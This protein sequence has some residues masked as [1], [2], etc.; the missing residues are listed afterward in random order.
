MSRR[1]LVAGSLATAGSVSALFLAA[2]GGDSDDNGAASGTT[3][4]GGTTGAG[5]GTAAAPAA[6]AGGTLRV[7]ESAAPDV[8]D[9]AVT[10]HAGSMSWGT[11]TV[12]TGLLK[13]DADVQIVDH[14]AGLPEQPDP[15]TYVFKLK[16][17]IKWHNQPPANGREFIAEDAVYGLK[18]FTEN[19]PG[20]T[21]SSYLEPVDKYEVIDKSTFRLTTKQ[22]FAPLLA[23]IANDWCMMVNREQREKVG[24]AGMKE[25]DNLVG[26]GPF[27]RGQYTPNVSGSLTKNPDYFLTG[28][29]YLDKIE[30]T[31]V[32]DAAARLA[33]FRSKQHDMSVLWSGLNKADSDSL[34]AQFGKD[35][36]VLLRKSD[37]YQSINFN[38]ETKPFNDPRVRTAFHLAMDRQA[39]QAAIGVGNSL[40]MAAVPQA[41]PNW[42]IPEADLTKLPG[43]R[44]PKDQ[45][46]TQAKQLL[47]AA[48]YGNGLDVD[49]TSYSN[50]PLSVSTQAALKKVGVNL[51]LKEGQTAAVLAE[52]AKGN[53]TMVIGS[54]P[55][56]PD[57]DGYLFAAFHTG[58]SA[59][60]GKYSNAQ[61]DRLAEQQRSELDTKKRQALVRQLQELLL[62]ENPALFTVSNANYAVHWS[63]VKNRI[64][65]PNRNQW[66]TADIWLDK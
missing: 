52:R 12:L 28:K 5:Q 3:P 6:K 53:F 8:F 47:T 43:Y 25:Y 2:C 64:V 31:V 37:G 61:V 23:N 30:F 1:A 40:L 29:P 57:P 66:L 59:N 62:E 24:D 13:T 56:G 15:T 50:Y 41:L 4:A 16:P 32:T 19:V 11:T 36:E 49:V 42:A 33:A 54:T 58:A 17:G 27:L 39:A 34:K 55:G 35:V 51:N 9:P 10:I 21:T 48:G 65:T 26:T 60:Y 22:P 63:Y 18:R 46:V 14:M 45:D 38:T 44:Q 20:F 7:P